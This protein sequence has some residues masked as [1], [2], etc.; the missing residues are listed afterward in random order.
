[1]I[2]L[3]FRDHDADYLEHLNQRLNGIEVAFCPVLETQDAKADWDS[4][5]LGSTQ[6]IIISSKRAVQALNRTHHLPALKDKNFYVVGPSTL[7]YLRL[8]LGNNAE[9]NFVREMSSALLATR[10]TSTIT[11]SETA[12]FVYFCAAGRRDELPDMLKQAGIKCT[13]LVVYETVPI[14]NIELP[15]ELGL[16]ERC[17]LV[18]FSPSGVD[19]VWS[20]I[21]QF[22]QQCFFVCI[23]ATTAHHLRQKCSTHATVVVAKSPNVD[24]V[25]DAILSVVSKLSKIQ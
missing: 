3:L 6:N 11:N 20:R 17:I 7:A 15:P 13:E 1:M 9:G 10:I 22:S 8:S 16:E 2:C 24:G 18:F 19:A 5:A 4:V 14:K 23:G 12:E 21:S 25:C